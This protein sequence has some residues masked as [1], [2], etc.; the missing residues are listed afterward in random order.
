MIIE[1]HEN[2]SEYV[3]DQE[4]SLIE[5]ILNRWKEYDMTI[6]NKKLEQYFSNLIEVIWYERSLILLLSPVEPDKSKQSKFTDYEVNIIKD[7]A[8][9][10]IFR[11]R[12]LEEY[13]A[14]D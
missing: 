12:S 3:K 13:V 4:E 5:K 9:E 11:H 1:Q 6:L 14:M 7:F 8:L 10:K 2:Y